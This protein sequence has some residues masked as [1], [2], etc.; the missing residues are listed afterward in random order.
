MKLK[1][2]GK[3]LLISEIGAVATFIGMFAAAHFG[4]ESIANVCFVACF[5][6]A[7]I[8]VKTGSDR[9]SH[10]LGSSDSEPS[11]DSCIE[12]EPGDPEFED[13]QMWQEMEKADQEKTALAKA[14]RRK[15]R[16]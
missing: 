2:Q 5:V 16:R 7:F 1:P 11:Y 14:L 12:Y 15:H 10:K 3:K 9:Y 8:A 6:S 4:W 13:A